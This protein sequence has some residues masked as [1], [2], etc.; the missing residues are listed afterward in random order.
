LNIGPTRNTGG[1]RKWSI[2]SGV[3]AARNNHQAC[4]RSVALRRWSRM[5]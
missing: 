4:P 1:P 2:E 3:I 5:E